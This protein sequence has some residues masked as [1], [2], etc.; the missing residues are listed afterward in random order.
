MEDLQ[1][2]AERL[3]E[4]LS[5]VDA[6]LDWDLLG[7]LYCHEGGARFF[8]EEQRGAIRDA[9]LAFAADL[10]ERLAPGGA[11]HYVGAAVA[12]LPML[13]FETLVLERRVHWTQL[14][15]PEFE[16][17]A[18]VMSAVGGPA[19]SSDAAP[20]SPVDHLWFVSVLTDPDAFPALHDELYGR[21]TG[22]GDLGSERERAARLVDRALDGLSRPATITTTDEEAPSFLAACERRGWQLT[23]PER[24]RL[25]G[26]VGDVVRHG[27]VLAEDR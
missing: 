8:P 4:A 1:Q 6:A 23:F 3:A 25:S 12:E 10:G 7:D 26:I 19:P 17:L 14:P 22:G 16:E 9:G 27:T 24:G 18:R 13:L 21:D 11:S 20:S 5:R 2:R 15:G